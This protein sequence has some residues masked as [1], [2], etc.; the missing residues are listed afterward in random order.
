[1]KLTSDSGNSARLIS[2]FRPV[3]P[4]LMVTRNATAARVSP[5]V[6]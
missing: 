4:I 6:S 2:K 1:M 3:C 5:R